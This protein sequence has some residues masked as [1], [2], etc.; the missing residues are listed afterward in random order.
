[1]GVQGALNE[2]A[3]L[4]KFQEVL[5]EEV[6]LREEVTKEAV[7]DCLHGLYQDLSVAAHGTTGTLTLYHKHYESPNE[8]AALACLLRL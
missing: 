1:M 8:V 3:G 4:P 5:E 6:E 7:L 2:M